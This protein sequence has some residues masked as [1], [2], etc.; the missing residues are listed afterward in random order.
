MGWTLLNVGGKQVLWKDGT[1]A[2]YRAF[3]AI[4]K[5]NKKASDIYL[6]LGFEDLSHFSFAFKKQ[7]GYSSKEL[8]ERN[9]KISS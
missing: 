4:D 2:G 1:T 5:K 7:F 8:A 6:E 9:K 3:I